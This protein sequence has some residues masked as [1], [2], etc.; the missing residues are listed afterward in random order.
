MT[1]Q[2]A[3]LL[4]SLALVSVASLA[5][6]KGG[7][8]DVS[9]TLKGN[10]ILP[11]PLGNPLFE[12]VTESVGQLDAV[13]QFPI[14]KGLGIGAGAKMTWF[15]INERALAPIVTSGE[16]RRLAFYGKVA[17]ERYT[18]DRTFYEVNA[19]AGTSTYAFDCPTCRDNRSTGLHWGIGTGY[20]IHAS[21]N[22]AFGLTLGYETDGITFGAPDLGLEDGFP[23]RPER[24]EARQTQ[25]L[26]IGMGFSTRLRKA[27]D[28]GQGW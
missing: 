10:L 3:L 13:I 1:L 17:Y 18:S 8:P 21:D 15:S 26:I 12:S 22:L 25:Y 7:M 16:I 23:G 14:T 28:S 11:V 2:R 4:G 20:Y 5:Q 6:K 27:P 24:F 9:S 19:R